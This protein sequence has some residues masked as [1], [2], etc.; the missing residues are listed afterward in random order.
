M[1]WTTLAIAR[2]FLALIVAGQHLEFIL[3]NDP[4]GKMS[5][6]GSPTALLGFLIISGFSIA[7][8]IE[9]SEKGF[10]K[11]R[12]LRI[13]P[14][15]LISI[16]IACAIPGLLGE[17]GEN[18]IPDRADILQYLFFLQGFTLKGSA[19]A[20]LL[21]LW[22]LSVEA[23]LYLLAPLFYKF[24]N[25]LL[26]LILPLIVVYGT[27]P[28][29]HLPY[30]SE[31]SGGAAT[32]FLAWFWILGFWF[33]FNREKTFLF[34]FVG[35]L[36]FSINKSFVF[37]YS[38]ITYLGVFGAIVYGEKIKPNKKIGDWLGNISYPLYCCHYSLYILFAGLG[39]SNGLG[40][41]GIAIALAAFL[42]RFYDRPIKQFL[43]KQKSPP[44]KRAIPID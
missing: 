28:K 43:Q 10:Y 4:I 17:A 30:Y 40:L 23:F 39:V 44:T 26:W 27:Y 41:L 18:Y 42:D 13:Y 33:W 36:G 1:I 37:P 24:K 32:L 2:F 16:L 8:S 29:W 12:I 35:V 34:L 5:C 14:I 11:R 15:Y 7:A 25:R 9:K 3:P 6:L 20:P 19:F 22:S 31:M 21:P 38:W